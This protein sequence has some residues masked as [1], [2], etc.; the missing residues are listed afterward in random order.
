MYRIEMH[1]CFI[2][3]SSNRTVWRIERISKKHEVQ[4]S[5]SA[6]RRPC[7]V[8]VYNRTIL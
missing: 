6:I 8:R 7:S 1:N 4:P 3:V 2:F 5:K